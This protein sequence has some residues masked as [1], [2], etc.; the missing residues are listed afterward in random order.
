MGQSVTEGSGAA[1][2]STS[3]NAHVLRTIVAEFLPEYLTL[4]LT[5]FA[6]APSTFPATHE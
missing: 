6:A 5:L 1:A 2:R 3:I 4:I